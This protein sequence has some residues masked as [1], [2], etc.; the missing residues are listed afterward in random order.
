MRN[1]EYIANLHHTKAAP[2]CSDWQLSYGVLIV[3]ILEKIDFG[4]MELHCYVYQTQNMSGSPITI[5]L[6]KEKGDPPPPPQ[7]MNEWMNEWMNELIY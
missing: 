5:I 6:L 3:S 2:L 7:P 1:T 4:V